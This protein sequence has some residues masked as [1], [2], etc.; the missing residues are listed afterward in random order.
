[1]TIRYEI[2]VYLESHEAPIGLLT[3]KNGTLQFEYMTDDPAARISLAL[4]VTA[5]P[6]PDARA[7]P[8]F[9]NLLFEN[10]QRDEAMQKYDLDYDDI[11]GLLFNLG[12][13]CPGAISCVPK[14][15]G[16]GKRPGVLATDYD[17]MSDD[18]LRD[19]IQSLR[20]KRQ[21]TNIVND[22]SPLAG[23]Q[24]KIAVTCLPDGS[25][26]LPR[27]GVN[28]PTTHILKVP[29]RSESGLVDH[30]HILMQMA[31][32]VL[33]HPVA[34][35]S[36]VGQ[37]DLRGLL[38]ERFDRSFSD[39]LVRRIHQED[40]CQAMGL[41][42]SLKYQR[43]GEFPN[44]FDAKGIGR[45]LSKTELPGLARLAFFDLSIF[46]LLVG[47]TDGHAKNYALLHE[48]GRIRLAPA[49]DIV[50]VLYDDQVSHQMS[51]DIGAA[52][53]TEDITPADIETY[54]QELGF[55]RMTPALKK[56][57]AGLVSDVA[58]RI[59]DMAGLVRKPLGD[60]IAEQ[61]RT[62]ALVAQI[63]INISERDLVVINRPD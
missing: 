14:G 10:A 31:T 48:Q 8:F 58:S 6:Y 16:P 22:P 53:M 4:P 39:G 24:G 46:N 50:P 55:S 52:K 56:R 45:V 11:V 12:R 13:D 28:A 26:A 21:A 41:G 36:I 2:D 40:F 30:E 25:I 42:P 1:M 17:V 63:G 7:R 60:V 51:F 15:E 54:V 27:A 9:A 43:R 61:A 29:R 59:V 44:A 49:Y 38:I 62:L 35:T 32:D 20:D 33:V 18:D 23:V 37:D 5:E 47:N 3:D 34:R 57:F 19:L